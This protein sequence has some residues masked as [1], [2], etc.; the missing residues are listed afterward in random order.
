M[1]ARNPPFF[2]LLP[3]SASFDSY[4][5]NM[6][7]NNV[8]IRELAGEL[9]LERKCHKGFWTYHY[10]VLWKNCF[11]NGDRNFASEVVMA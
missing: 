9:P 7:S 6:R 11:S 3:N 2:L 5:Q 4:K 10:R 8:H 1:Q